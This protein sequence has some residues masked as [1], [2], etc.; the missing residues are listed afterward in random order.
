MYIYLSKLLPPLVLPVAIVIELIV[1][2]LLFQLTG[3]RKTSTVLML[4][5]L[6][7]LYVSSTPIVANSLYGRLE[8]VYP[9]IAVQEVPASKCIV[10]LGGS[11]SPLMPPRVDF[12]MSDSIDRVRIAARLQRTGKGKLIIATAGGRRGSKIVQSAAEAT[13]ILLAEWGVP[14][15][16]IVIEDTSRNTRENA[17][18]SAILLEEWNCGVPLLVTSALHMPRSV[19]AFKKVG[20]DVFPVPADV[21]VIR[22]P[23]LTLHDWIPNSLSLRMTTRAL[24]ERMGQKVYEFRGWN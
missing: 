12:E 8:Q 7:V 24:R 3:K 1:L 18:N 13:R 21:R 23:G 4:V 6:L 9:P 15:K 5:A 20:V 14:A 22:K 19:A 11:V 10:L 17:I 2:A 16:A